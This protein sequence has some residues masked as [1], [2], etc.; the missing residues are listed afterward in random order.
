V[1]AGLGSD[2]P[3]LATSARF[4]LAQN[5]VAHPRVLQIVE[6]QLDRQPNAIRTEIRAALQEASA[7]RAKPKA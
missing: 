1:L 7:P 5:A 3:G 2:Q 6:A 4:S